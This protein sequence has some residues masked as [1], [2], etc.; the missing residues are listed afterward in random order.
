MW[1]KIF[2]AILL[3]STAIMAF[4]TLYSFSWLQS[5]G[6]P[7]AA[8]DGFEY[9][10]SLGWITLLISTS[11]LLLLA[12][13]VYWTS[14]KLW[15]LWATFAYFAVFIALRYFWLEPVFFNF[16]KVHAM[17]DAAFSAKPLLAVVLIVVMAVIVFADQLILIRLRSRAYPAPIST[18]DDDI[19]EEEGPG[20]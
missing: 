1:T 19:F 8:V 7:S 16:R 2:A 12:N 4:F 15:A 6:R 18:V 13:A 14:S 11:V 5:I 20:S 9:H 17:I 3:V 10:A